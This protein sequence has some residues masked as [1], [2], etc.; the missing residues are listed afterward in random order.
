MKSIP[1]AVVKVTTPTQPPLT[2]DVVIVSAW[3]DPG[4]GVP[5]Q[6]RRLVPL[7]QSAQDHPDL[8]AALLYKLELSIKAEAVRGGYK[9]KGF[10]KPHEKLQRWEENAMVN[11]IMKVIQPSRANGGGR[12]ILVPNQGKR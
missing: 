11:E 7:K 3:L 1:Y 4:P 8:L 6:L 9:I 12:R 10:V 5:E 2:W